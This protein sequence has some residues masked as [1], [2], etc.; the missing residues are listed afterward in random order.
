[1]LHRDNCFDQLTIHLLSKAYC[2]HDDSMITDNYNDCRKTMDTVTSITQTIFDICTG[3]GNR[4][5]SF[6]LVIVLSP[7][8]DNEW[9]LHFLNRNNVLQSEAGNAWIRDF[10]WLVGIPAIFFSYN[11]SP[12]STRHIQFHFSEC[13]YVHFEYIFNEISYQVSI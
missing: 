8:G 10:E 13:K 3:F 2:V 11:M 5:I 6:L 9:P 12:C 4:M 1:M 7:R